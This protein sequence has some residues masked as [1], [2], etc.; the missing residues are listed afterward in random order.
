M[1]SERF[2]NLGGIL[3]H[4][5]GTSSLLVKV[6]AVNMTVHLKLDVFRLIF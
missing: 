1:D 6:L 4:R 5:Q 2:G 3:G